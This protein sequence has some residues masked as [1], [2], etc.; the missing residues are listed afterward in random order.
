[1][2]LSLL[3]LALGTFAFG[4]E[5]SL[6][7]GLLPQLSNGLGV[8]R[9]ATGQLLSLFAAAYAISAPLLAAATASFDRRFLMS[10]SMAAFF[11][12][13]LAMALAPNYGVLAFCFVLAAVACAL[14]T[15][16]ATT[17]ASVL[18]AP[19][20]RGHALGV[21]VAGQTLGTA[22]GVPIGTAV[23]DAFGWRLT[24]FA[25][26][27]IGAIAALGIRLGLARASAPASFSLTQRLSALRSP[28]V[29]LAVVFTVAWSCGGATLNTYFAPYMALFGISGQ[30]FAAAL[31]LLGVGTICAGFFGG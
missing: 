21:I 26:A 3:W 19:E 29:Q 13:N 28:S 6:V 22:L 15:P 25:V 4:T 2:P 20:R 8:S 7:A 16:A 18:V 31:A 14:Y 23:G 24:F 1:M 10:T 11:A 12:I 5:A 17:L 9:S 30:A 27:G